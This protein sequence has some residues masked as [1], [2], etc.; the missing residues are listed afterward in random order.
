VYRRILDLEGFWTRLI[1]LRWMGA[2]PRWVPSATW[3]VPRSCG[4]LGH[5]GSHLPLRSVAGF[6]R[7]IFTAVLLSAILW[8]AD[9]RCGRPC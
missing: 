4:G 7:R 5:R 9:R 1:A 2:M 8:G 3:R 6:W